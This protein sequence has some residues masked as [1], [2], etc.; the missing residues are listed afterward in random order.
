M[1]KRNLPLGTRDEL[2]PTMARKQQIIQTIQTTFSQQGFAPVKTPVLEYADVFTGMNGG[3]LGTYS[4]PTEEEQLVLRPDL[5]MPIAR[6]MSTTGIVPPVKLSYSGDVFRRHKRHTGGYDQITQAGI[7][8]IGYPGSKAEEEC[9]L[10]AGQ[11]CTQLQI[12]QFTIELGNAGF[13]DLVL[14]ALPLAEP[15]RAELKQALIAKNLSTYQDRIK[16]LANSP[17]ADFLQNWPWLFGPLDTVLAQVEKLPETPGVAAILADLQRVAAFLK[18]YIPNAE[19]T[20]DLCSSAP[21]PYYTG[22]SFHAYATA[23]DYLFSG[24]RYDRLLASFQ[25]TPL[26]AVGFAF[27]VDAL[28]ASVPVQDAD[29]QQLVYFTE[30]QWLAA[31]QYVAK[32]PNATLCLPRSLFFLLS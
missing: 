31:Q 26:A 5:T 15:A 13:V 14:A 30:D 16:P 10:L 1:S 9:L 12:K 25:Q 3:N 6:V 7:E 28:V 22:L 32:R 11:L 21:Q 23:G 8:I 20:L 4:L 2:G 29:P 24:G 27:D 19:V 18:R 17:Y